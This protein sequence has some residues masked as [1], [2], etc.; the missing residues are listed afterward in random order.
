MES[1]CLCRQNVSFNPSGE[2]VCLLCETGKEETV[3]KLR[4]KILELELEL[5]KLKTAA[6]QGDTLL[7]V[8]RGDNFNDDSL[9]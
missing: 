8:M 1:C 2:E 5:Q 3:Q 9:H 4:E 7:K 6:E